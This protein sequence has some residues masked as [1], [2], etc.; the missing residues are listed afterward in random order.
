MVPGAIFGVSRQGEDPMGYQLLSTLKAFALLSLILGASLASAEAASPAP[1]GDPFEQLKGDWKGGGTVIL[2]DGE[3]KKVDCTT[4]YKVA[5]SNITQTLHCK[6]SDYEVN[7]TLKV[8]D[9]SGKI[10]GTWTESVYD[11]SGSVTGTA[12]ANLIHALIAGD[13]FSGRMSIKLTDKGHT[14]NLVKLN[15]KTGTY[16]IATSLTLHR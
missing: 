4:N 8:T 11:A 10:K 1:A 3:K 5:G 14:I 2:D 9:K 16:R 6:G 7:T 15:A 12:K 13:K